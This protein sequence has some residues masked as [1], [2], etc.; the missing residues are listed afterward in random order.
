MQLTHPRPPRTPRQ[1]ALATGV[2]FASEIAVE[3]LHAAADDRRFIHEQEWG[4]SD[5]DTLADIDDTLQGLASWV[6]GG[7]PHPQPARVLN[8]LREQQRTTFDLRALLQGKHQQSSK[9]PDYVDRLEELRLALLEFF[10]NSDES[11]VHG[12]SPASQ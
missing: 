12:S 1:D 5:H 2:R 6:V 9:L 8:T 4:Q 3:A 11:S 10:G 7:M